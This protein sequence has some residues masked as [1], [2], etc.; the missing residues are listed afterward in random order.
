MLR[1]GYVICWNHAKSSD[2]VNSAPINLKLCKC[3][4]VCTM[5]LLVKGISTKVICLM[6]QM[7]LNPIEIYVN[8][9]I[10]EA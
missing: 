1:A 10:L 5:Q 4:N 7:D 2:G 9:I 3:F 8:L 6:C